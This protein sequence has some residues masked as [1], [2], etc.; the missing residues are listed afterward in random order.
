MH[1]HALILLTKFRGNL[2]S[3]H[4]RTTLY[5]FNFLRTTHRYAN[6][7]FNELFF[8]LIHALRATLIKRKQQSRKEQSRNSRG[9]ILN[10]IKRS[11]F[12][13]CV[14]GTLK[15]VIRPVYA[16]YYAIAYGERLNAFVL[17]GSIIRSKKLVY[18]SKRT[19]S[20]DYRFIMAIY[21]IVVVR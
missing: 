15:K 11:P 7:L 12:I 19:F 4:M 8:R 20:I 18:N 6:N 13:H 21:V 10:Q 9:N 5:K 14:S 17:L 16:T 2:D 3:L 1:V